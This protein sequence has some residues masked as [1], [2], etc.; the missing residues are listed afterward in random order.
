MYVP[1]ELHEITY[2]KSLSYHLDTGIPLV[3]Q[4]DF[5]VV[6]ILTSFNES[7]IRLKS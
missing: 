5:I 1:P 6:L 2:F 3:P 4:A 7:K